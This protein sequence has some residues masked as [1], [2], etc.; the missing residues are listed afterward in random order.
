MIMVALFK[1]AQTWN[2]LKCLSIGEYINQLDYEVWM[3]W[4]PDGGVGRCNH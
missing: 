3:G 4:E 2:L 1:I